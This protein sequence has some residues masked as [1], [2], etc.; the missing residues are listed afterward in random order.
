MDD[1]CVCLSSPDSQQLEKKAAIVM[2]FLLDLCAQHALTPNVKPGKT[3]VLFS[4]RGTHAKKLRAK[5]FSGQ[6]PCQLQVVCEH[7]TH[8]IHIAKSY[9]HLGGLTHHGGW[10]RQELSRRAAMA[11]Q[12]FGRHRKL[13]FCNPAISLQKRAELFNSVV[14]SKLLYNAESW[15]LSTTA[16]WSKWQS[17]LSKLHRRLLRLPPDA[18]ATH[19]GPTGTDA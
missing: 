2:G 14:L 12:A 13:L 3:E 4:F 7:S 9:V 8:A 11:H 17:T 15:V 1:L 5:Y 16:D 19:S 6:Q 18:H 10:N